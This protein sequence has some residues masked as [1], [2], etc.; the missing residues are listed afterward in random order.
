MKQLLRNTIALLMFS[1]CACQPTG[2]NNKSV[3]PAPEQK[4]ML[5]VLTDNSGSFVNRY[6]KLTPQ[7]LKAFVDRVVKN[8]AIDVR[9]GNITSDSHTEFIRFTAAQN[10]ASD[11]AQNPW[12]SVG[13]EGENADKNDWEGFA[14]S[15]TA[16]MNEAPSKK[17]D[18]GGGLSHALLVFQ[19][20]KTAS[21]KILLIATDYKNNVHPIPAI[22]KDIEVISIGALPNVPI[23]KKLQ[24]DNVKRFESYATALEFISSL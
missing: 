15:M 18:I 23:E 6:T 20:A 21:R 3:N 14:T 24:T 8:N 16:L 10:Q 17:S 7:Q 11:A 4:I 9:I 2:R 13:H 1:L 22:D 19:E 12:M 5:V